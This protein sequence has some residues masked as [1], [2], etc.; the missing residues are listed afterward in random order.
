MEGEETKME[1][2]QRLKKVNVPYL[3][4]YILLP[5][6]LLILGG[7][8]VIRLIDDSSVGAIVLTALMLLVILWWSIFGSMIY[9]KGERRRLEELED[10]GFVRNHT[11][12]SDGCV[13]CVDLVYGQIALMFRWNP[14]KTFILPASHITRAWVE[15]GAG[16]PGF[17]NG[18]SRV[19]FAFL[20]DGVKVRVSTFTSN[21]RWRMESDNVLTAIS[22]ADVMVEVLETAAGLRRA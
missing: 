10:K 16:G 13:V 5:I 4:A 14:G 3:L 6:V 2:P 19:S 22:K 12:H 7:A 11:F 20:V 17:M 15:D 21:R 8:L 9:D 1:E 18:T